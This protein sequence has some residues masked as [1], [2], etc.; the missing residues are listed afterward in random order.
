MAVL[1]NGTSEY[2]DLDAYAGSIKCQNGTLALRARSDRSA[3]TATRRMLFSLG[4]DIN[5]FGSFLLGGWGF[6]ANASLSFGFKTGGA[7]TFEMHYAN[8]STFLHDGVWHN[9]VARVDGSDNALFIDGVKVAMGFGAGNAGTAN[10]FLQPASVNDCEIGSILFYGGS[11]ASWM[12][13]GAI[14]DVRVYS[15]GLTDS[16]CIAICNSLGNDKIEPDKLWTRMD[17]GV[18][19]TNL[20]TARDISGNG[21]DGTGID[22]PLYQES[23]L[24]II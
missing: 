9:Y 15:S 8:G 6:V 17:D 18:G 24:K 3:E 4:D 22:T 11:S 20:A 16:A 2:I 13:H 23:P 10:V 19:G 1:L 5:N 12:H 21:Y 7:W 14:E